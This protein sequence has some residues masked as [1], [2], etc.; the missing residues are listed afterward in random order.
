MYLLSS[1][2][3]ID[4]RQ[5]GEI[6]YT[7]FDKFLED[8]NVLEE[9]QSEVVKAIVTPTKSNLNIAKL[10][11]EYDYSIRNELAKMRWS[12]VRSGPYHSVFVHGS[13]PVSAEAFDVMQHIQHEPNHF[14]REKTI[15]EQKWMVLDFL[16]ES[17]QFKLENIIIY[18]WKL[19]LCFFYRNLTEERGNKQWNTLISTLADKSGFSIDAI[20]G[21]KN[22]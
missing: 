14:S 4:L 5:T 21:G 12:N 6:L 15:V 11:A 1:L 7:N 3:H 2:P 9:E 22:E 13:I 20:N 16:D 17:Y 19:Q 8:C 10:W 18:G